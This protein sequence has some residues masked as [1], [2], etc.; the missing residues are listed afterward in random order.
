MDKLAPALPPEV[1]ESVV[2]ALAGTLVREYRERWG[3]RSTEVTSTPPPPP[4]APSQSPWLR[5]VDAAKR[6]QCARSTIYSEVQSG[7]LRAAKV[8]GGR[9]LRI[10][11]EWV[12][13]WLQSAS[14]P[15]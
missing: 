7:H 1:F 5:V 10:R 12:D 14:T 15:K 3:R 6:A 13:D 11:P 8:S 9:I 2:N 4:V